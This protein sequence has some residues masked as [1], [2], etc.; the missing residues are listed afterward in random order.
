VALSADADTWEYRHTGD[1]SHYL[2]D[3]AWDGSRY[4]G[5]GQTHDLHTSDL[6]NWQASWQGATSVDTAIAWDGSQFVKT[7]DY[8][9]LIWDG[10]TLH[11][12]TTDPW[13]KWS[14]FDSS[15][16][17]PNLQDLLWSGSQFVAVGDNGGV[18]TSPDATETSTWTPQT[19]GT[20][21][22]LNAVILG[23]GRLVAVGAAG[24]ILSSDNGGVSWTPQVSGVSVT[25]DDV[26]WTGSEFI[27]VGASG[28]V[29]T[30]PDG[31]A[32][33]AEDLGSTHLY[34]VLSSGADTVI[35]GADGTILRSNP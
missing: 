14:L 11:S 6:V 23:A 18:Y 19:S 15:F 24:T 7:T 26:T 34:S 2:Y 8:G 22:R 3:L 1:D 30:S 31:S 21:N 10:V 29:L 9:I 28:T 25:L 27:A 12:G 32:W 4:L 20:S 33:S 17:Y 13:W 16:P 35:V 5:V